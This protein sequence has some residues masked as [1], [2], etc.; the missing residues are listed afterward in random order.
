MIRGGECEV[1][2]QTGRGG[3]AVE[4]GR[5]CEAGGRVSEA[6]VRAGLGSACILDWI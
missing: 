4:S 6:A 1:V 2:S 5:D 3:D